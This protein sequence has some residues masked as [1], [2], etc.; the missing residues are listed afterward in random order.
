[1]IELPSSLVQ[2]ES[3]LG[4]QHC[5]VCY[6]T[7]LSLRKL[8]CSTVSL[9]AIWL[10]GEIGKAPSLE[11]AT[12]CYR[13][14]VK[15]FC[16]VRQRVKSHL[17]VAKTTVAKSYYSVVYVFPYSRRYFRL[18]LLTVYA[19]HLNITSKNY[20]NPSA[21]GRFVSNRLSKFSNFR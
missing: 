9:T 21:Q 15:D 16:Y 2:R 17:V 18:R 7:K 14:H 13:R 11:D 5:P 4:L 19:P 8:F 12:D 1:M 6:L 20:P 10:Q 3:S